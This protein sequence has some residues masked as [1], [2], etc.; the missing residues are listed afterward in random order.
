MKPIL[1]KSQTLK[2]FWEA[3]AD[4][5]FDQ[6][7]LAIITCRSTSWCERMRWEG[8]GIP[9]LKLGHKCL[10]RKRDV[11][12]WLNQHQLANSTSE[13]RGDTKNVA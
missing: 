1:D 10:Y 4:A 9:F 2:D 13:Y 7:T 12:S 3:P 11:I 5:L 6:K 8:N